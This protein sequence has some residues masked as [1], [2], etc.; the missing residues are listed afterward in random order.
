M[1]ID[2][3]ARERAQS[4]MAADEEG[5]EEEDDDEEEGYGADAAIPALDAAVSAD[6]DEEEEE[7]EDED[8]DDAL[9]Y[10]FAVSHAGDVLEFTRSD[11]DFLHAIAASTGLSS[12]S[13]G[14]LEVFERAA[15]AAAGVAGADR[16]PKLAFSMAME[17]LLRSS[18]ASGDTLR[19]GRA[20]ALS[21][22]SWFDWQGEDS[23]STNELITGISVFCGGSK[24]SKMAYAFDALDDDGQGALDHMQLWRFFRSLLVTFAFI[25]AGTDPLVPAD[26]RKVARRVSVEVTTSVFDF[27][28]RSAGSEPQRITFEQFGEWYNGLG[29]ETAPWLELLDLS[30]WERASPRAA[31]VGRMR[32]GLDGSRTSEA[33]TAAA[34]YVGR[35][36]FGVSRSL[37]ADEQ[38][39]ESEL[40]D[41]DED[42]DQ[43]EGE[44]GDDDE[45]QDDAE[46]QETD[47]AAV[48][49]AIERWQSPAIDFAL[50]RRPPAIR[51]AGAGIAVRGGGLIDP[52]AIVLSFADC[53]V[54]ARIVA[55]GRLDSLTATDVVSMV[56]DGASA[57]R[58][59]LNIEEY[60]RAIVDRVTSPE[61]GASIDDAEW[62]R[63]CMLRLF[64]FCSRD[65]SGRVSVG[66]L[67]ATLALFASGSKTDK[68]LAAWEALGG[69]ASARLSKLSLW[70]LLRSMLGAITAAPYLE[71]PTLQ[72]SHMRALREEVDVTCI[73]V[74]DGILSECGHSTAW[75]SSAPAG[76]PEGVLSFEEFGSWYNSGG[77]ERLK[78]LELL[79]LTKW[80]DV[81][82]F[83]S[84]DL[85]DEAEQREAAAEA[86][87]Q[88]DDEDDE[89]DEEE[90]AGPDGVPM[91]QPPAGLVASVVLTENV[92]EGDGSAE[93]VERLDLRPE[94]VKMLQ[95]VLTVTGMGR[96][97]PWTICRCVLA[98]QSEG[99]VSRDGFVLCMHAL[100]HPSGADPD[101][102]TRVQKLLWR[103]WYAVDTLDTE[104]VPA[105]TLAAALCTLCAGSKSNKIASALEVAAVVEGASPGV[106]P[107]RSDEDQQGQRVSLDRFREAM[108]GFLLVLLG[109][110]ERG[111]NAAA[112]RVD[113]TCKAVV[114][115]MVASVAEFTG[116]EDEAEGLSFLEFGAWYNG[117][118]FTS[119]GWIEL[120]DLRK[121]SPVVAALV[122]DGTDTDAMPQVAG[123]ADEGEE[124]DA[125]EEQEEADDEAED[126][127]EE[128]A[129]EQ[130]EADEA[131]DEEEQASLHA[132][133]SNDAVFGFR[134]MAGG[135]VVALSAHDV[136]GM[137]TIVRQA[138]LDTAHPDVVLSAFRDRVNASGE[139]DREGF[140]A[141][142]S[143]LV[144]L[145][146]M[147]DTARAQLISGLE[148]LFDVFDEDASGTVDFAEFA[149]GFSILCSGSKS[150]KLVL[151]FRLFDLDGDNF[152]T[153]QELEQ[154]LSSFV[155]ALISFSGAAGAGMARFSAEEAAA[156]RTVARDMAAELADTVME[157]A[158]T[159][160]DGLISFA[161][162]GEWYNNGGFEMVPWMEMLSTSKWRGVAG[163]DASATPRPPLGRHP[164]GR[165][166]QPPSQ[167]PTTR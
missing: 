4:Q 35:S 25:Q 31:A 28:A 12:R 11:C 71:E 7:D 13:C 105:T 146:D 75:S 66:V 99:V 21:L 144:D 40:E 149:A 16:L 114:R 51:G 106:N 41:E 50:C 163:I 160:K 89:D 70:L 47:A 111:A 123:A 3:A 45:E 17:A 86:E 107:A 63:A 139:L 53:A 110:S 73:S 19:V 103:L 118:G 133:A 97:D 6:L 92:D 141:A 108:S 57:G 161:E 148:R 127:A 158:D 159:N 142:I 67:A 88:Q 59:S 52:E 113:N 33:A 156:R 165:P 27:V 34:P 137:S 129:A 18:G 44:D 145:D 87:Q 104:A 138:R 147:A 91:P 42:E 135:E 14:E 15:A 119:E 98:C 62:L 85:A 154:Y 126:D 2:E 24:S 65:S 58:S 101:T 152:I 117:G 121:W 68:L 30:K 112:K 79:D 37:A 61:I 155:A 10:A 136:A 77:N 48:S 22:F 84:R 124:A 43:D 150:D 23:V 166:L 64:A 9:I 39:G 81:G 54:V 26:R 134:V 157:Q 167:W 96:A 162:F 131:A 82:A 38:A 164:R 132:S 130:Q 8:G 69:D 1:P 72:T 83:E 120:L 109:M 116:A 94:D 93:F 140:T 122:G 20:G 100:I 36:A 74:V 115:R 90:E 78:W 80:P 128:E 5:E 76:Q 49:D 56:T 151:A 95:E 153:R 55:V 143:S 29:F 32:L 60:E 125:G 102:L 46:L